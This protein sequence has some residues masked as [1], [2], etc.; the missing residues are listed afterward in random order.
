VGSD[1][2]SGHSF[3]ERLAQRAEELS[4][5]AALSTAVSNLAVMAL[6]AQDRDALARLK[7]RLSALALVDI[8]SRYLAGL[9]TTLATMAYLEGDINAACEHAAE[10]VRLAESVDHAYIMGI[11]RTLQVMLT[12]VRD[13]EIRRADLA[14]ALAT[15]SRT[16]VKPL[17]V[18]TLW[19]VALYATEVDRDAAIHWLTEAEQ[20]YVGIA[21][22]LWP[23][24]DVRAQALLALGLDVVPAVQ[25]G[26][27]EPD[28]QAVVGAASDWLAGRDQDE[29]AA[30]LRSPFPAV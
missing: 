1:Q 8:P 21:A 27:N 11:G 22:R 25:R 16:A 20:I 12:A 9:K 2:V 30:Q 26:G 14:Q 13:Q 6:N 18:V 3:T 5:M 7:P 19:L 10:G 29:I 4:D 23:E 28:V 24:E 15:A 17:V